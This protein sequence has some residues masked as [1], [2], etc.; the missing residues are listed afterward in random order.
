V[1]DAE[2]ALRAADAAA[3]RAAQ[4]VFDRPVVLEAGAGTGKTSAL[5]ARLVCWC[6]GPGWERAAAVEAAR[7]RPAGPAAPEDGR[8]AGSVLE[9]VVAITFTDA[10]AAEMAARVAKALATL[11]KGE[12]AEGI[13][14]S[15]L[16]ADPGVRR[17]RA[18]SLLLAVDRLRVSTI[19]AFC[20]R[21]LA[22]NP[23]EAGVHPSF[24]V[25]ADG[26][27]VEEIVRTVVGAC[28]RRAAH[29]PEADDLVTLA[30]NRVGPDRIAAVL[31]ELVAK[32]VPE[33]ALAADPFA[34]ERVAKL[35]AALRERVEALAA[36]LGDRL[37]GSRKAKNAL[38]LVA[39]LSVLRGALGPSAGERA[40]APGAPQRGAVSLTLIDLKALLAEHLPANLQ[41]HLAA[42]AGGKLGVEEQALAGDIAA[43]LAV[44]A[45]ELA[46][47]CVHVERADEVVLRAA[48]RALTPLLAEIRRKMRA[49]GVLAF[50]DLLGRCR[51]LLLAHPEAA[52]RERRAIAQLVVD[53]F[54]D[55]DALQC[56]IVAVLALDGQS[57]ERPGLF[58][59]GDPKQSIYGWRN[60]DLAAYE[61]FVGRVIA[62]GG[63]RHALSVNF[64][65]VPAILAEVERSLGEVMT[66]DPGLQPAFEPL[67]ACE[68]R[69][70]EAGFTRGGR[71]PVEHWVADRNAAADPVE[72]EARAVAADL[73]A[74]H[75]GEGVAWSDL[76]VL[77]RTTTDLPTFLQALRDAAVPYVVERDKTY[78]RRRE[79][80]EASA[81][82]RA[83][84]DPTDHVALVAWLRS[85]AVGV[86]D[87][88]WL[89]LW[90]NRFP[91]VM[92]EL[93]GA[94]AGSLARAREVIAAAAAATPAVP[95]IERVAG[96]EASLEAA[97]ATLARARRTFAERPAAELVEELR[98][99]TLIEATEA[100]RVLGV[101]R[102]A[103]LDLFF[104]A[105]REAM[106]DSSS[107]PQ[108]VLRAM[109]R[110]LRERR[111]AEEARLRD[112]AL[113]AVRVM[114]IH[115]AKGLDFEHVYVVQT[116]RPLRR[117]GQPEAGAARVDGPW[118][119][120]LFRR[121]SPGW[122][123]VSA[124][125][126]RV[127]EAELVRTLYVAATRAR[128]RLVLSG[129]W[130]G[131][132]AGTLRAGPSHLRLLARRRGG[133]PDIAALVAA[134]DTGSAGPLAFAGAAWR[135]PA[136]P[137]PDRG[138]PAGP[139][140]AP[141]ADPAEVAAQARTLARLGALARAHMTRPWSAPASAEAHRLLAEENAGDDGARSPRRGSRREEQRNVATAAGT[142]VHGVLERLDLS[143][144]VAAQLAAARPELERRAAALAPGV[145]AGAAAE[146]AAA[147]LARAAASPLAAR[148]AEIA[149]HVVARELPVLLPA[150]VADDGDPGETPVAFVA[151]AVDLVYR[152]PVTGELVIADY[153]T[154][155]VAS[156]ADLE[157]RIAGY[158]AQGTVYRRALQD[159]LALAQPPRFELW[160][161]A[162][163][164]IVRLEL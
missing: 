66:R 83:V 110:A 30:A 147:A 105:L 25:D 2:A 98:T 111:E 157:K 1:S 62:A 159:A 24:V 112:G 7:A 67:L 11:G 143:G 47:V 89:P 90:A 118:E 34:P 144:D 19:H 29:G 163:A 6:L 37:A 106:E 3:R 92:T 41:K 91:E 117:D 130:A 17:E 93:G 122:W 65:S 139:V 21:L 84:L 36:L 31:G 71:S 33:L 64:R 18:R 81:L 46:A 131:H 52:A 60:A 115:K 61:A 134:A 121:P 155:E 85:A 79:V 63:E 96:W 124:R 138:H 116:G 140:A 49:G 128:T 26:A 94:D 22:A 97:V 86:P 146:R 109:R 151:G 38:K 126:R 154:D 104:R 108:E 127:A 136:L 72:A 142:L 95:G 77:M 74:L 39:A 156:D 162:L 43:E 44:A 103:N 137:D 32:G 149:P 102:L 145:D 148:L 69:R 99:A 58:L 16:P 42:W 87:A 27:R 119:L 12:P 100:A 114:T 80:L 132:A 56:E 10:A 55:T 68:E 59:V 23:A 153:K 125:T 9:G 45:R 152:D 4:T 76:A 70:G 150:P 15:A 51:D 53:E 88:A 48:C 35:A 158:R 101:Y 20:N 135:V 133:V 5:V 75:R 13:D 82:V 50:A 73:A 113:D 160:F 57:D 28:F 129:P 120:S 164:R 78:Y 40:G 123:A 8:V 54:Q 161:L 14:E 141:L 107:H